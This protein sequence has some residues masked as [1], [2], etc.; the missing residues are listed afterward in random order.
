VPDGF[1]AGIDGQSGCPAA[2]GELQNNS[3]IVCRKSGAP[4]E[5]PSEITELRCIDNGWC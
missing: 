2:R 3:A 1:T 4:R 5:I